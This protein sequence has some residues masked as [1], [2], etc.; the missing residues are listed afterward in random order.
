[1]AFIKNKR[2]K[3][4][5]ELISLID[6]IFILLVFFLVTSFVMRMPRQERKL[7]M[8]T[9]KNT[10]G[11][12]QIL[13][14]FIDNNKVFWLDNN[15]SSVVEDIEQNYGYLSSTNLR[16]KIIGA[17]IK[18]NTISIDQLEENLAVLKQKADNSPSEKLFVLIR[19]PNDLPFFD[20]VKIIASISETQ[21]R[22]LN[23]GC[24]GGTF[25]Q[26]VN[27]KRIYN[28][29]GQDKTGKHRKDIRIDF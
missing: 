4:Q 6:M 25:D 20:V 26:I 21:Y 8:P 15:A 17:L 11:R 23:Y 7:Y 3:E 18:M 14:Q 28:V 9:P 16:N 2:N 27:C 12:A 1:M 13:I 29:V 5:I 22:N 19:C 24:V 10:L